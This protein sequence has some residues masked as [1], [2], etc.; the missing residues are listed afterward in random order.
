MA[1]VTAAP[2]TGVIAS[3][4]TRRLSISN[5]HLMADE[6]EKDPY[7]AGVLPTAGT[8]RT[9]SVGGRQYQLAP[10]AKSWVRTGRASGAAASPSAPERR[11]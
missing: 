2:A 10:R 5:K 9:I 6:A 8:L 11:E 3:E 7:F 1:L 4:H